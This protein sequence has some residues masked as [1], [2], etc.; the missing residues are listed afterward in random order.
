[1]NGL[2]YSK[3]STLSKIKEL[4]SDVTAGVN[5]FALDVFNS[6]KTVMYNNITGSEIHFHPDEFTPP[7]YA[8]NIICTPMMVMGEFVG[9]L[10]V[11]NSQ[12][13]AD[14]TETDLKL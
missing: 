13:K 4:N 8:R 2:L 3:A 10:E 11:S 7:F 9:V 14:Y 6:K 12:G 1:E 5:G